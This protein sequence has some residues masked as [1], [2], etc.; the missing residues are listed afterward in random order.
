MARIRLVLAL[1][2]LFSC[3]APSEDQIKIGLDFPLS[4][5]LAVYGQPL[6]EGVSLAVDE[7]NAAGGV[8][9]K[10]IKIVIEDN[11]GKPPVAA[12]AAQKLIEQDNVLLLLSTLV[13]PTGAIAPIT[14]QHNKILLYAAAVDSF[15]EQN[16]LVFKDSVDSFVD[17]SLLA[18]YVLARGE[19]NIALLGAD[20]EFTQ[21][22]IEGLK[23][24]GIKPNVELYVKGAEP[25]YRTMLTKIKAAKPNAIVLSAYSDDCLTIWKNVDELK[26]NATFLLPFTQT[27]CGDEGST[28]VM[29]KDS[30]IIGLDFVIDKN[31][32]GF[33]TFIDSFKK[34]YGK[35]PSLLFFTTLGYDWIGY[36]RDAIAKCPELST[37]C[38]STELETTKYQGAWGKVEFTPKH[39]TKRPRTLVLFENST[40]N[41]LVELNS[42][43]KSIT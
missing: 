4:G 15:A 16:K 39:V 38:I 28:K 43:C 40:C 22:C 32:T 37:A 6:L 2:V 36:L 21:K 1:L 10:L 5:G 9:G 11:Q 33:V 13:G 18:E 27:G 41:R 3:T 34:K 12:I 14:E 29:P 24:K 35:E 42:P 7:I 20:T 17:C 26:I 31:S 23:L 25:D 8:N 19:T 30:K